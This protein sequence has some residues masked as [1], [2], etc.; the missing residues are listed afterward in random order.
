VMKHPERM[1]LWRRCCQQSIDELVAIGCRESNACRYV[2]R[3]A[4]RVNLGRKG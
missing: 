4:L 2:E 1:C 3:N